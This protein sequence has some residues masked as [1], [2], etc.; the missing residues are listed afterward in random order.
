LFHASIAAHLGLVLKAGV[1]ENCNGI[2][3]QQATWIHDVTL[4]IPG[5]AVAIK[6]GFTETLPLAGLL[7]MNG[8]FEHFSIAF[9]PAKLECDLRRVYRN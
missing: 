4:H 5:G 3:G 8:F 1:L 6:A 7:G 2:G 9:D